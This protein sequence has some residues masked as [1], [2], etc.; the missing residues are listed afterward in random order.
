MSTIE[1]A[2][3]RDEN[4]VLPVLALRGLVV[5]P[6]MML[7]FDVG[8]KK[9]ILALSK[10]MDENQLIFLVAQ[11]DLNEPKFQDLYRI[12]VVAK[13]KQVVRHPEEGVRVFVEGLYRAELESLQESE[14]FL[15]GEVLPVRTRAY[16]RTQRSEALIRFTQTLFE[17]YL[18][19]YSRVPPDIVVGVVQKKSSPRSNA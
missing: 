9:S 18:Q 15:L 6:G 12:G 13:I 4:M 16:R 2:N 10:A 11:K 17:Q 14:P 1:L 5:F 3:R 19:N 8:R 7:Q